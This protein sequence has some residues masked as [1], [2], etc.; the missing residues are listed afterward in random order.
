MRSF[1]IGVIKPRRM[2]SAAHVA[3]IGG[4]RTSAYRVLVGDM[5]ER[6]HLEDLGVNRESY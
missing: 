2:R 5:G 1:I 4:G 3:R 6:E